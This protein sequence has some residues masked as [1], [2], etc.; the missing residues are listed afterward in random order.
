MV[1]VKVAG[2]KLEGVLREH[3]RGE[4]RYLDMAMYSILRRE[5]GE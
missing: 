4:G 3:E 5:W 1:K 2:M